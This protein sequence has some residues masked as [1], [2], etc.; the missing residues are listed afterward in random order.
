MNARQVK[1]ELRSYVEGS[2]CVVLS[3][4]LPGQTEKTTK[5]FSQDSLSPGRDFNSGPP[6]YESGVLAIQP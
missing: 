6:K 2:S 1:D 3:L 4:H 5:H